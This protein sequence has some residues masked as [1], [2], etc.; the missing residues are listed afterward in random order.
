MST[1]KEKWGLMLQA[2]VITVPLL[3]LKWLVHTLGWEPLSIGTLTSSL[4]AGVFFVIAII[5]AGVMS[6]FKEA[7]R[8]LGDMASSFENLC[9]ETELIG[10]PQE[11][12]EMR[13]H[14]HELIHVSLVNFRRSKFWRMHEVEAVL[15]KV[16]ADVRRFMAE[17]K[18]VSI[19]VRLR[20][21]LSNIRK[22]STRIEVI[23]ETTFLP[24]AHT[25]AEVGVLII[26][27]V[28]IFSKFDPFTGELGL[29]GVLALV[30]TSVIVLINDMDNPFEGYAK[31]DLR[32][33]E[34]L[35]RY[36]DV[37]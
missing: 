27:V 24:A 22:C 6:D 35:D 34:K 8:M 11:I 28:L 17:G 2:L 7:E 36:L 9:I 26:I 19:L 4:V 16:E 30:L 14:C 1:F 31:L 29:L 15:A 3:G 10:S 5:L 25:V 13:G 12:A 23:K 20:T 33:I 32:V 21:E 37:E 18:N